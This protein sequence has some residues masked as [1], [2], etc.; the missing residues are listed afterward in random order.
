MRPELSPQAGPP[1]AGPCPSRAV[2]GERRGDLLGAQPGPPPAG[3]GGQ[4]SSACKLV[5]VGL[6]NH[7]GPDGT[8]AF[9]SVAKPVRYTGLSGRTVRRCLDRLEAEGI[10]SPG[11]PDIVAARIKRAG[12][13]PHG[14]DLNLGMGRGRPYSPGLGLLSHAGWL[15][16]CWSSP[17]VSR[18]PASS[19]RLPRTAKMVIRL[20]AARVGDLIATGDGRTWGPGRNGRRGAG[21]ARVATRCPYAR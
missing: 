6:A 19:S 12:R 4:P 20:P 14:W 2:R 7:A 10:I 17:A 18:P 5:P 16:A 11:D 8:G 9:S 21:D 15:T 13:W 3:R 1:P